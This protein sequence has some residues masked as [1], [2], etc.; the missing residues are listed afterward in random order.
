MLLFYS[1]LTKNLNFAEDMLDKIKNVVEQ[2]QKMGR[3]IE[4]DPSGFDDPVATKTRWTRIGRSNSNFKVRSL[5]ETSPGRLEFKSSL[6]AY[7]F[8][9][10]FVIIGAAIPVWY[11]V[12]MHDSSAETE[13]I[14]FPVVFGGIFLTGG[15][16]LFF[17]KW[18]PIII[19]KTSGYFWTGKNSP[20]EGKENKTAL[21]LFEIHAVQLLSEY[22]RG[23]KRSYYVYET[24][25]VL[26]NAERANIISQGGSRKSSVADAQQLASFLNVP[27]WDAS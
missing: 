22:V 7:M 23:D 3:A 4:F 9:L 17:N 19:D 20:A 11:F 14:L 16:L 2:A 15:G 1:S 21:K 8:S 25:F 18:K 6:P 27:F 10:V 24:N 12:S 5:K 13:S 26:K